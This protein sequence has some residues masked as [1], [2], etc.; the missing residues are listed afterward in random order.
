MAER[1]QKSNSA[2]L[3]SVTGWLLVNALAMTVCAS[4]ADTKSSAAPSNAAEAAFARLKRLSG[5][6][7]A[8]APKSYG[9]AVIRLSYRLISDDSVLIETFKIEEQ[10]LE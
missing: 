3:T 4:A 8:K 10:D 7:E 2:R 5:E 1:G 6:W 9:N